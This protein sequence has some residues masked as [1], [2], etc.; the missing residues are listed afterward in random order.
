M[1]Q[2]QAGRPGPAERAEGSVRPVA[3][4]LTYAEV[5]ERVREMTRGRSS[6]VE[7][8]GSSALGPTT[9]MEPEER[10]FVV[11]ALREV[12][13]REGRANEPDGEVGGAEAASAEEQD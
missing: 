2:E 7:V 6:L 9:E 3:T 5:E 4:S 12:L 8:P 10:E 11:E 1:E 13:R